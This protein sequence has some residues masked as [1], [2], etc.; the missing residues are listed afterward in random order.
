MIWALVL[1]GCIGAATIFQGGFN[2]QLLKQ[3]DLATI[4]LVNFAVNMVCAAVLFAVS[5]RL[6]AYLPEL[7]RPRG[8]LTSAP[9]WILIPG[10]CGLLIV[11]GM[12][13][14]IMKLGAFRT[15]IIVVAVQLA[16]SI[17]WDLVV[18][19]I[20]I[21]PLRVIGAL[22]ACIGVVLGSLR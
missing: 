14:A 18:D 15:I 10:L 8:A 13:I 21:S 2:R 20:V 9:W 5:R 22:L 4:L 16:V 3:W 6:P 11:I 19:Q 7:F 12:P 17:G 1:T